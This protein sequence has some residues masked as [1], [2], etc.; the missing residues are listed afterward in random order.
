[1]RPAPTSTAESELSKRPARLRNDHSVQKDG[2]SNDG[3][4]LKRETTAG[5]H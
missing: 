2:C 5:C 4:R 1:M 3:R